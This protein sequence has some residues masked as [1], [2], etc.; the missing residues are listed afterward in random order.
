ME[1]IIIGTGT[2]VPLLHRASPCVLAGMGASTVRCDTGRETLR[3][4]LKA[5]ETIHRLT[6]LFIHTCISTIL[7]ISHHFYLLPSMLPVCREQKIL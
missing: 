2:A 5:G 3:Q 4:M 6:I 7:P 1:I